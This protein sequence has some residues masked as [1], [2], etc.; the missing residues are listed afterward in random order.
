MYLCQ[1]TLHFS[2]GVGLSLMSET[3]ADNAVTLYSGPTP[4]PEKEGGGTFVEEHGQN[5]KHV[6]SRNL[7]V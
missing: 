4:E 2:V 6:S 5:F 1:C 7:E 3:H